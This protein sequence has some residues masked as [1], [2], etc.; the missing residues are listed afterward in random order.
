MTT[1][2]I[3]MFELDLATPDV[4]Y[5]AFDDFQEALEHFYAA[6]LEIREQVKKQEL[7]AAYD[8]AKHV[9]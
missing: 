9:R 2:Q 1:P 6:A 3:E 4:T 5:V 8:R 7:V